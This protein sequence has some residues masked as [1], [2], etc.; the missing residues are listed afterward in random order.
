MMGSRKSCAGRPGRSGAESK[1][2][3]GTVFSS[4]QAAFMSPDQTLEVVG[5]SAKG[6]KF[7]N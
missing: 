3:P 1:P 7:L 2:C 5:E 4:A 6:G